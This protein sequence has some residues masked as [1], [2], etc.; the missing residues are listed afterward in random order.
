MAAVY[1]D[2]LGLIWIGTRSTGLIKYDPDTEQI[3][4]YRYDDTNPHSLSY[5]SVVNIHED[6]TGTL[7]IGTYG[8]GLN[9]FDR[10]TEQFTRYQHDP[11]D[12]HSLSANVITSVYEDRAGVL[13]VGTISGG[14]NKL[15]RETGAFIHYR[16]NAA[17]SHSLSSDAIVT[18]FEGGTGDF[19]IGTS[20]GLDRFDRQKDQI[21]RNYSTKHGLPD[22]TV[23]VILEDEQ[24]RLW[25]GTQNGMSRFDPQTENFRNYTISD[26]LQGK[27]FSLYTT[28]SKSPSGEMFFPGSGGFNAFYPDQI[29]D[30]LNAP[31]VLITD[32]QLANKPVPIR[33][34]SVL[35]KSILETNELVLSYQDNVFSFEFVA[36]DYRDPEK[37]RY[38]Y[39]MD[40]FEEEWNEVDSTRRF[41]TYTNLD[42]GE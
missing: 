38:K 40:G 2:R 14:V 35:R 10:E 26:G 1:V 42:P 18:I 15:D 19:W 27:S 29:V 31:P 11:A 41:A 33:D 5:D 20:A 3:T 23:S 30:N 9:A 36:L 21:V 13:W 6:R 37:D 4:N 24:G 34:D 32:F 22:D 39:K 8:G 28:P 25:L 16:R 7:W 12:P 17:D